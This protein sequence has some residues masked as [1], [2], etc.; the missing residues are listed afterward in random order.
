MICNR[1][2]SFAANMGNPVCHSIVSSASWLEDFKQKNSL[3]EYQAFG[4]ASIDQLVPGSAKLERQGQGV[5]A[6]PSTLENFPQLFPSNETLFLR[7]DVEVIDGDMTLCIATGTSQGMGPFVQ[8][9]YL[10]MHDLKKR[11]FSLRR[12]HRKSGREVCRASR[13]SRKSIRKRTRV[14][15]SIS[16][17]IS[18][19]HSLSNSRGSSTASQTS[20][21]SGA[22]SVSNRS[23]SSAAS[24]LNTNMKRP[25]RNIPSPEPTR[26]ITIEFSNYAHVELSSRY[27]YLSSTWGTITSTN[28]QQWTLFAYLIHISELDFSNTT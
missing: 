21:V 25:K 11:E 14:R 26:Q 8:L 5:N 6:L 17:S 2:Q 24:C 10:K 3:L 13:V 16:N 20:S 19:I 1:A 7:H 28:I 15:R 9:F 23:D 27:C 4:V 22:E 18:S 12:Y